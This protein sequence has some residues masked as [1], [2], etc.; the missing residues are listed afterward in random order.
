MKRQATKIPWMP[1]SA[2]LLAAIFYCHR[3]FIFNEAL[4][5]IGGDQ[6]RCLLSSITYFRDWIRQG[7]FPLWNTLSMCGH[8]FGLHAVS[9]VNLYH[10]FS[11]W[12]EPINAYN[13]TI[14]LSM[15]LSGI[16]LF[17]FLKRL[18]FS[19]F[20]SFIGG[21]IWMMGTREVDAGFFFPALS[22]YLAERHAERNSRASFAALTLSIALY[23]LNANPQFFL[24]G[25]IFLA[26][27]LFFISSRRSLPAFIFS[28][29]PFVV[30]GGLVLFYYI[31]LIELARESTRSLWDVVNVLLPTHYLQAVFPRIFSSPIVPEYDFMVSR[32][33]REVITQLPAFKEVTSF[34][35]VPYMGLLAAFGLIACFFYERSKIDPRI[36]YFFFSALAVLAYL[37]FHPFIYLGVVRHLPWVGGMTAVSRLFI[38]YQFSLAVL[39]AFFIEQVLRRPEEGRR[40]AARFTVFFGRFCVTLFLIMGALR[41]ALWK[42]H[43]P[44]A[45]RLAAFGHESR[46]EGFFVFFKSLLSITNPHLWFPIALFVGF[47]MIVR[48]ARSRPFMFK[49]LVFLFV[50]TD[51]FLN[52]GVV[53]PSSSRAQVYRYA[54]LADFIRQDQTLYRVMFVEDSTRNFGRMFLTPASNM[55][56]G[57]ATPDGYEQL[58]LKRYTRYYEFMMNWTS[59]VGSILHPRENFEKALA[60][61]INAKYLVTSIAN[62]QFEG[63]AKYKKIFEDKEFKIFENKS[64]MPRV[65]LMNRW[66]LVSGSEEAEALIR[67]NPSRL[68]EEVVIEPQGTILPPSGLLPVVQEVSLR[69]Y[70]PNRIVVDAVAEE[71]S[72]LVL[73]DVY[74]PGWN[75][76]VDGGPRPIHIANMAFRA[77]LL[78]PGNHTIEFV[79]EP[80]SLWKGIFASLI[81]LLIFFAIVLFYSFLERYGSAVKMAVDKGGQS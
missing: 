37:T 80:T 39:A 10:I 16:F 43:E 33:A 40:L 81:G 15:F 34:I 36:R 35:S 63:E 28:T 67:S 70:G 54:P 64:V 38:V 27:Y 7:I 53:H 47:V 51:L 20:S 69:T 57:I 62:A 8:T 31:R 56:Y 11:F 41:F 29:L 76:Y 65:F 5:A 17:L 1:L 19:D 3:A 24:Y 59:G 26:G 44:I 58:Y 78:E 30:A 23:S 77:V 4:F 45:G 73:S 9:Y 32:V 72:F 13:T 48:I 22:F 12:L 2:F 21:F 61:F 71:A 50:A 42:F 18:G 55:T 75:A 79:F 68:R 6:E 60:D 74:Y 25:A 52:L 49:A 14:F 66:R 46:I